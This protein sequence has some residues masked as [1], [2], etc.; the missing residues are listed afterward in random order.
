[1]RQTVCASL[2]LIF[3]LGPLAAIL[4]ANS[5][6]RLPACCRR[7]GV[8][9]CAMSAG[10][11]PVSDQ[12]STSSAPALTAPAHC[13]SYPGCMLSSTGPVEALVASPLTA[14]VLLST[15]H[16]PAAARAA[17][18]LSVLRTRANRGPPVSN[19]G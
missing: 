16:S 8:H 18:R 19:I 6:L 15:T 4:P 12:S 13:S 7:H 2:I 10:M 11:A 3:W 1:M 9:H 17:A 5:E 14:P